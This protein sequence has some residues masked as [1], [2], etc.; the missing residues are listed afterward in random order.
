M[1]FKKRYSKVTVA[2]AMLHGVIIGIAAVAI[3]GALILATNG[4]GKEKAV[5]N[6][7][8]TK[9]PQQT[10][11]TT[12]TSGPATIT[13]D[14]PLKLFAK[15]HG[16]F[17]SD[18]SAKQLIAENPSLGKATVIEVEGQYYVWSEVGVIE[19][20]IQVSEYEGTFRKPFFVNTNTCNTVGAGKLRKT[21]LETE[22]SQIKTLTVS[23]ESEKEDPKVAEFRKNI[24]AVTTFTSDL[25]VIRA[26]LLAHYSHNKGCAVI[27]F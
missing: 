21:L 19:D 18:E 1:N 5:E 22:L 14:A 6:E 16:V 11:E 2:M 15:Q 7:V 9:E 17:S 24:V 4:K 8:V 10:D 12:P 13:N 3:V 25:R 20:E 26:K 23:S 27:N